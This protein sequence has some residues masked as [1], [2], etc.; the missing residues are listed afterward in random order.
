MRKLIA[1][2]ALVFFYSLSS[3]Q[4]YIGFGAD[5]FNGVHGVL[6]NPANIADSRTKV[7]INLASASIFGVNNYYEIN[8]WDWL[9]K[10]EGDFDDLSTVK[11]LDRDN[12]GFVNADVLGPSVMV[13]LNE[14]HSF[15]ITTRAR[16]ITNANA[17][18]GDV[19]NY[20][21]EEGLAN[22]LPLFATDQTSSA[23]SNNW[24]ELGATYARVLKNTKVRFMK[25]GI[26]LKY[27]FGIAS[28]NVTL[29]NVSALG[30]VDDLFFIGNGGYTYS[31][32]IDAGDRDG[33]PFSTGDDFDFNLRT[34]GIGL[35]LGFVY[36]YRPRHRSNVSRD[37]VKEQ[38]VVRHISTYKYKLGVSILDIGQIT[39]ASVNKAYTGTA[40]SKDILLNGNF[41]EDVE[42]LFN[43]E[44]PRIVDNKFTLPTRL[45]AE[46][47]YKVKDKFYINAVT[48]L[49]LISRENTQANRSATQF[50]LSPRYETKWFSM[51]SPISVTVYG[52]VQWGAGFRLGPLFVGSGSLF[53]R[54]IDRE[55]RA[56]DIY[57]G[58]KIPIYHKTP[59]RQE[60]EDHIEQKNRCKNCRKGQLKSPPKYNEGGRG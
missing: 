17:V 53:S 58:L 40:V 19:I 60:E 49:T 7:D 54:A 8:Y 3:A 51:Y 36:E 16:S 32:S 59:K 52:G 15:A 41:F 56:F 37:H 18:S 33:V 10:S 14:K 35:D 24:I 25:A 11:G 13:S 26:S 38:L 46:I 21:D 57:A 45:R 22:N 2:F 12:F 42:P 23:I 5:N 50:S 34:R 27:L 55:T 1:P 28:T 4:S 30:G 20:F 39:Y 47:D 48:N 44:G 9:T 43:P 29:D 31:G 6:F